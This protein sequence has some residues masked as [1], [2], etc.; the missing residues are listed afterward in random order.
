MEVEINLPC[1]LLNVK[2]GLDEVI[3]DGIKW[4]LLTSNEVNSQR[5]KEAVK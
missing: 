1:P 5:Q 3:E 4:G 2:R